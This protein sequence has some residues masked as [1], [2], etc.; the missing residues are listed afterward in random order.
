MPA[1][2]AR[3]AGDEHEGAASAAPDDL[4]LI[5][6][7]LKAHGT[8]GE[9]K[10]IPET[11][12]PARFE[13]LAVVYLGRS[14][15]AQTT[16][17][18]VEAVRHQTTKRGPLVLLKLAHIDDRTGAEALRQQHVYAAESDLPPLAEDESF[19]HDL[20]GLAVVS[21]TGEALGTVENVA[22]A[23]AHDVFVVAREGQ[24]APV[25]IP[26]VEA[27]VQEVDLEEGRL[28]VRPIEGMF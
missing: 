11:D 21:E 22:Q 4:L 19:I 25:L 14:R 20:V 26:A 24:E 10:V 28:V 1:P 2:D 13:S 9:L 15:P 7:V 8:A 27:F 6:R 12:D 5:G 16:P 18:E 23:P 3:N 17:Y